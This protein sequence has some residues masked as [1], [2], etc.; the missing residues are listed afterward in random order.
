MIYY[1]W[2]HYYYCCDKCRDDFWSTEFM[3]KCPFCCYPIEIINDVVIDLKRTSAENEKLIITKNINDPDY[4]KKTYYNV[5]FVR[6][7]NEFPICGGFNS[8]EK[9]LNFAVV[10][11][12]SGRKEK[13]IENIVDRGNG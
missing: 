9:A 13:I 7:K 2:H 3:E 11:G 10:Y 12:F 6:R 8:K 4:E 5:Y 1:F